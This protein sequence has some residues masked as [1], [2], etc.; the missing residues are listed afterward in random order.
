MRILN[1]LLVIFSLLVSC[2]QSENS[3]PQQALPPIAPI[4]V[5]KHLPV[6]PEMLTR[7]DV[8]GVVELSVLV[9]DSGNVEGVKVTRSIP[10]LDS[11]CVRAA[12]L[13]TFKPG[14]IAD[15]SGKYYPAK[16][17]TRISYD[18]KSGR[19]EMVR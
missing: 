11:T 18:W 9:N 13:C 12:K 6:I 8:E 4:L 16:F 2:R 1:S 3:N 14:E 5:D 7:I 15:R 19:Q 10:I 17:W